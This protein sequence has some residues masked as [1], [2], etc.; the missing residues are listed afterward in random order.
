MIWK[1]GKS[2]LM[3]SKSF[4]TECLSYG[5]LVL[6]ISVDSCHVAS[7]DLIPFKFYLSIPMRG[8][9]LCQKGK[10]QIHILQT[11]I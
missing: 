9:V 2:L 3:F 7:G 8:F 5:E 11:I 4:L 10:H 6:Q 1:S